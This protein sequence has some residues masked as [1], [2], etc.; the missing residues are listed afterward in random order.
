MLTDIYHSFC[1]DFVFLIFTD[2]FMMVDA[3]V[4]GRIKPDNFTENHQNSSNYYKGGCN[5]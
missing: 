5:E 2:I 4:R 3:D 1:F